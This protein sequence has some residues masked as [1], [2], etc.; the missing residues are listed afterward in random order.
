MT[1]FPRITAADL[2]RF[3]L[4][5]GFNQVRQEGSHRIF[6]NQAGVRATIPDHAGKILHPKIVKRVMD[7]LGM[8]LD[9]FIRGLRK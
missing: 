3:L 2:V 4:R 6:R 1:R 7:D 9:A 5:Q 8:D